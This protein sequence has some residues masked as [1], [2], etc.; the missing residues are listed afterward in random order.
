MSNGRLKL[1]LTGAMV[2]VDR[3]T[4]RILSF[5]PSSGSAAGSILGI[6]GLDDFD[7]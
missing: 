3:A 7:P 1:Q 2:D 6:N 4:G 5:Q